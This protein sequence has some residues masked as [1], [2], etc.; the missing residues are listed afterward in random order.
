MLQMFTTRLLQ[1]DNLAKA[2]SPAGAEASQW[3]RELLLQ[4]GDG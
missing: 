4:N 1:V 2:L 3:Q